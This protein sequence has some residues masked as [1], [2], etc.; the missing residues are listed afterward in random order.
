MPRRPPIR[1]CVR[2]CP[3]PPPP[4]LAS[5]MPL[6]A[7]HEVLFRFSHRGIWRFIFLVV[8]EDQVFPG[9][10]GGGFWG[11]LIPAAFC[12]GVWGGGGGA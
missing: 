8:S 2:P 1:A 7:Q 3:N 4:P 10:R 9:I 11:L 6:S 5:T 12:F